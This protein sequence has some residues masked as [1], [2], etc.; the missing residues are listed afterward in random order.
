MQESPEGWTL[1]DGAVESKDLLLLADQI[2]Y[3]TATGQVEA[4]GHIRM[5]GPGLR[6]RCDRLKMDWTRRIGEAWVL[7]LE[8]PPTWLLHSDK[9]AFNTMQH[10]EFD[11]VELSPCPQEKPGWKALALQAHRGPG[12]LRPSAQPLDLGVQPAHLLLP[13]LGHLPGQGRAHLGACCPSPWPSPAPSAPPW[14]LPYYQVLGRTAD[15]TITPQ[16]F[17]K[18]GILWSGGPAGPPSPPTRASSRGEYI[19]QQ[20]RRPAPLPNSTLKELWQREDGWQFTADINRASDA[21]LDSD[22]GSGI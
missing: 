8:L 18:E 10:W 21:L 5:E 22:Y 16:Y 1:V 13:A 19:H 3:S 11:K 2:H 20:H 14:Q 9:V 12:P 6:L 4:E 15:A 7:E 17:T